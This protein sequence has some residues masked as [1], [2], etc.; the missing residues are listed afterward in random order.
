[1]VITML[2]QQHNHMAVSYTHLDVYKRQDY[3]MANENWFADQVEEVKVFVFDAEGSYIQIF[4]ENG[5][6][7]KSPDYRMPVSY[8]H[9]DVYKRQ[10]C[11]RR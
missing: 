5:S 9:L 10:L 8:T 1:M 3:N 2:K 11:S 4:T 7:L 6:L